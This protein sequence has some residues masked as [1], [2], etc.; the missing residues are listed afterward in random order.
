MYQGKEGL[1]TVL[2]NILKEKKDYL[3]LEEEGRI[4]EVLPHFFPQFNKE[5]AALRIKVNVLAKTAKKI[6]KRP[7][8]NIKSLPEFVSFPSATVIYADKVAIFVWDEPYH[9]ILIQ[10]EQV[11]NSYKSFFEALWQQAN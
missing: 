11:A 7:L 3:V 1:K 4:Q 8:M 10:S 2:K 6:A 9:V 5:M